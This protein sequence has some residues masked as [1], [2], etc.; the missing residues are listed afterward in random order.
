LLCKLPRGT[1]IY[2]PL[3]ERAA[4][5]LGQEKTHE[6]LSCSSGQLKGDIWGIDVASVV[7][8]QK[9]RLVRP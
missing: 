2:H 5:E 3:T 4:A 9:I 1:K 7:G 6:R 8:A